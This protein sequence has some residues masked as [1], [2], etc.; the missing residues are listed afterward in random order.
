M[1]YRVDY[2]LA[3]LFLG[4]TVGALLSRSAEAV[5]T[6][7][8]ARIYY[9][10]IA[11]LLVLRTITFAWTIL[12]SDSAFARIEGSV[13][14]DL[15][16]FLFAAAF[17]LAIRRRDACVLL[18]D[19]SLVGAFY[20]L[21]SFTFSL[22]GLGKAFS[23]TPMTEFF[24]ESGYSVNFLRFIIIAEIFG[25]LGLLLPWA[26][27]PAW[28]GLTVDMFGAVITHIHNG[29]P[30]NDSTGAIGMLIKLVA[31]GVLFS[32]QPRGRETQFRVSKAL[33]GVAL[34][35]A[36]CFCIAAAGSAFLRHPPRQSSKASQAE[37][38]AAERVR[39]VEVRYGPVT[40]AAYIAF[41][42]SCEWPS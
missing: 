38:V 24:T 34:V 33:F 8:L 32:L 4:F 36:V 27:I 42:R 28:M 30:L 11:V 41:N 6:P 39:P 31:L 2:I 5:V 22:A 13:A 18:T 14:G 35:T 9:A 40:V 7:R 26:R 17:G 12:A 37:L 3:L 20:L 29:D 16:T 1:F 23:M 19:S 21:L 25:A 10:A 15:L